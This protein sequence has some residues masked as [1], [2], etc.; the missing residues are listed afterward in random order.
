MKI[1]ISSLLVVLVFASYMALTT[2]CKVQ[3]AVVIPEIETAVAVP[4]APPPMFPISPPE[5]KPQPQPSETY[6]YETKDEDEDEDA[7]QK[8][9]S[10]ETQP[11]YVSNNS[12]EQEIADV[13][14]SESRLAL[15]VAKAESSLNP[16][17]VNRN[18]NGSKD[19]GIFQINDRHGWSDEELFDWRTNIRIAKELRDSRGWREWV[20]FNNGTYK[21]FL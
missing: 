1:I 13:F 4:P 17:A 19:I 14:G 8:D 20:V 3:P 12:I 11:A 7:D 2:G 16:M 10:E 6:T 9:R 21:Q 18:R 15:A 5:I